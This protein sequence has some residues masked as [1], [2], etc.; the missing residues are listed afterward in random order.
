MARRRSVT[1]DVYNFGTGGINLTDKLEDIDVIS[2]KN[3]IIDR[4]GRLSA[5]KGY[6]KHSEVYESVV[7]VDDMEAIT[8]WALAGDSATLAVESTN[9]IRGTNDL[10]FNLSA[11]STGLAT[12][13]KSTTAADVT[14]A[15]QKY[16]FWVNFPTD[17]KT[18]FNTF[19]VYIGN[20]A[21]N[22]YRWNVTPPDEA[23]STLIVLDADNATEIGTVDTSATF[24]YVQYEFNTNAGYAGYNEF[25]ISDLKAYSAISTKP[26]TSL[27]E[28]EHDGTGIHRLFC[29][30]NTSMYLYDETADFW[31]EIKGGLTDFETGSTTKRTR[32]NFMTYLN[33]VYCVNG[34]DT[35]HQ[36]DGKSMT[37]Y[38]GVEGRYITM[39]KNR[40]YLAGRDTDPS[41]AYYTDAMNWSSTYP[42]TFNNSEFIGTQDDGKI[43]GLSTAQDGVICF[44][45][46]KIISFSFQDDPGFVYQSNIDTQGGGYGQRSVQTVANSLFY[47]S[48]DGVRSLQ[49]RNGVTGALGL[50]TEPLTEK[51]RLLFAQIAPGSYNSCASIFDPTS[52]NY[53]FSFNG[54]GGDVPNTTIVYSSLIG[55]MWTEVTYPEVYD[56]TK[57]YNAA[58]QELYLMANGNSGIIYTMN[59]GYS[60]N[61]VVISSEV[62]SKKYDF[63]D[64]SQF[65][66]A[67]AID[68]IGR[69]ALGTVI[70]ANVDIDGLSAQVDQ[71]TDAD[72]IDEP[73]YATVA[74]RTIGSTTIGGE[75]SDEE[76][77]KFR[78]LKRLPL[79][80]VGQELSFTLSTDAAPATWNIDRVS[81]TVEGEEVDLFPTTNI[82]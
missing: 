17:Y 51:L 40:A 66:M 55:K 13:T 61:G 19:R 9:N 75:E 57:W 14:N 6:S 47:Y 34:F 62:I 77:E 24:A 1:T 36:W 7:L 68:V 43:N 74:S 81:I 15:N 41:F 23:T 65:N 28:Y 69:K 27:F 4:D 35:L 2:A 56:Y 48:D 54:N 79:A 45:E 32:W 59:D 72:I 18:N 67:E 50:E 78:Y 58:E 44:K 22:C 42:V 39:F 10:K 46:K 60:D 71:I 73:D 12:L 70:D 20:D 11:Y 31:E 21:S 64:I 76:F 16:A 80:H 52:S 49:S 37:A 8:G 38:S 25:L 26:I 30:A 53:Y 5:R 3:M 29:T 63:G 33:R 82:G